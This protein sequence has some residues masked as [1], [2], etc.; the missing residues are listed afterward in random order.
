MEDL[1]S[2]SEGGH[3]DVEFDED[4]TFKAVGQRAANFNNAVGMTTRDLFEPDR[5][6]FRE[7]SEESRRLIWPRVSS[8][9]K[10]ADTA[11]QRAALER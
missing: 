4:D 3:L 10:L 5:F 8:M 11:E 1:Q 6:Y 9:F 7:Q 2:Q